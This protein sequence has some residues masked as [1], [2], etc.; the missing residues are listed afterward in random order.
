MSLI[1][2]ASTIG[3]ASVI[4]QLI[5]AFTILLMSYRFGMSDV[6]NYALTFSIVMIGIQITLYGSHLLLPKVDQQDIGKAV[7]FCLLQSWGISAIYIYIVSY[8]FSLPF[9]SIY[10]L[11]A[12]YSMMIISEYV[13][14]RNQNFSQLAIQRI[15]VTSVVFIA[16]LVSWKVEYFYYIWA[17]VHLCLIGYWLYKCLD[18]SMFSKSDF[19]PTTQIQF[20]IKHW[21]H[22]S[23]VGTAEVVANASLQLPTV[24]INYWFSPLVA[25][26]FAVVNRFCLS[27]VL[28]LGQSVRNYTFSKW[29]EDFRNKVFNYAEF[30]QVRLFLI[31]IALIT[32]AGIYFVYPWL[33]QHVLGEQWIQSVETSRLML[34]YVFAML[35][36]VPLTVIE[37]I[38]GTPNYFL[39]IQC[40][41]LVIVAFAFL[42]MPLIYKSYTVSLLA[43][44][45]LTAARYLMI[46][47]S[48]NKHALVLR[49][50]GIV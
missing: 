43:F 27:P 42:I 46:Y 40:E 49:D 29:S 11:T 15:S 19:L 6:G 44:T 4:S 16:L 20:F 48:I 12:S 3:G 1:K 35:A 41:Q 25:G 45:M 24:L 2:G 31:T 50:E 23:R 38:F 8:F 10:V 47:I 21:N 36:F 22:L 5:G 37:L 32:V 17:I 18:F 9:F 30:K 14:L 33:T 7:V 13:F 28:I 26:Y 39:R 34:P